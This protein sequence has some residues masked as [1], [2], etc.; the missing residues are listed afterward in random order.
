MKN[1]TSHH[2]VGQGLPAAQ[3]GVPA[4]RILVDDPPLPRVSP[5][6]Q[7]GREL[8][9]GGS[10]YGFLRCIERGAR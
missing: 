4:S 1:K 7:T 2:V 6:F 10:V 8:L 3:G 9:L 5:I